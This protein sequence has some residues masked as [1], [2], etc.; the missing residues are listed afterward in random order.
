MNETLMVGGEKPTEAMRALL[1]QQADLAEQ[2]EKKTG[3][4]H[5]TAFIMAG[6]EMSAL[7]ATKRVEAGTHTVEEASVFIGSYARLNWVY[8]Q[9]EMQRISR[10]KV[11]EM[12]PELWRSSDPDDTDPRYLALWNEAKFLNGGKY[13]RDG[14][15][16]PRRSKMLKVYRGQHPSA[17]A[18]MGIAWTLDPK[19]AQKFAHGGA[20]FRV[21]KA[22]GVV[23]RG[24]VS[25]DFVLAYLTLR[26]ESE[27][28]ID[29]RHVAL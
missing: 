27:V 26:H 18:D 23:Y 11:I 6:D 14:R 1:K 2:I 15:T 19:I 29:P 28:I 22:G 4:P 16:L 8:E 13:V 5:I 20:A 17:N 24:L 21:G 7:N 25:A 9:M 3:V 10:A 12:L